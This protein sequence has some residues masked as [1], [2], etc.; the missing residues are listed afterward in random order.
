MANEII[1][2]EVEEKPL[3][4]RESMKLAEL[5]RR[6]A[7][8]FAAFYRVGQALAEIKEQRLYRNQYGRTFAQYCKV[9]EMSES[10]AYQVI[11]ASGVYNYLQIQNTNETSTNCGGFE[12][13]ENVAEF[14]LP[15]N[16]AQIRPLTRFKEYPEHIL[17]IWKEAN[18]TAKN[19]KVTAAHVNKT[20]KKYLGEKIEK[21]VHK[22]KEKVNQKSST[23]FADAFEKFSEQILLERNSGYKYTSRGEIIKALD[24]LRADLAEDGDLIEDTVFR[25]GSNDANKLE[26]AGYS[27]FRMDRSS[28][29]IKL[30]NENGGWVKYSG[31][32]E[33][34]KA[35]EEAFKEILL[36]D[37]HLVG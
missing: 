23:D 28:M 9:W 29:N 33:T 19:G 17:S 34:L 27:M 13:E 14:P 21:T 10:R 4:A 35:M 18:V 2:M 11:D 36:D 24:Q 15:L 3:S 25:G 16:E 12:A 26:R 5:E 30:R 6:I 7:V 32:F 8:D 1:T 20:V 31:P 22:A 37:M